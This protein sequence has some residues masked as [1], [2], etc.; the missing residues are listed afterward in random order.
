MTWN[1]AAWWRLEIGVFDGMGGAD[2]LS[3]K[4]IVEW[5]VLILKAVAEPPHSKVKSRTKIVGG[6][7]FGGGVFD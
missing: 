7:R 5:R 1:K 4:K 3:A 6:C 2:E